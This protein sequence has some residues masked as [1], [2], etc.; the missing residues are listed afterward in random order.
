MAASLAEMAVEVLTT[1]DAR[2]KTALGRAHAERW[3][4]SRAAGTP[5]AIGCATPPLHP[6]RPWRP[7]LLDP[8][9]VPRR[10]PGSVS[11]GVVVALRRS[12]RAQCRAGRR[13]RLRRARTHGRDIAAQACAGAAA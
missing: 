10:R 9:D 6:A 7:E 12:R 4:A 3:L 2:E 13:R 11:S 5:L 8:R 1:A